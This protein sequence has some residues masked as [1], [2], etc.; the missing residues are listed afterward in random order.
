MKLCG[1]RS[2]NCQDG[3]MDNKTF[4]DLECIRVIIPTSDVETRAM[5]TH[6]LECIL[7]GGG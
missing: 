3:W 7:G 6:W 5:F 1:T 4:Y 2:N